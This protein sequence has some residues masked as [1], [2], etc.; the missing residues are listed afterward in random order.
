MLFLSGFI[1]IIVYKLLLNSKNKKHYNNGEGYSGY[2]GMSG[3]SNKD[4]GKIPKSI[5]YVMEGLSIFTL[6]WVKKDAIAK[7]FG[8][9]VFSIPFW[10]LYVHIHNL[11]YSDLKLFY[12]CI[13][14]ISWFFVTGFILMSKENTKGNTI[15]TK[16]ENLLSFYA[17]NAP[18]PPDEFNAKNL[19][20]RPKSQRLM[21]T[22]FGSGSMHPHRD[23]FRKHYDDENCI[24]WTEGVNKIT[25][26]PCQRE[27]SPDE[28]PEGLQ[29]EIDE[30]YRLNSIAY[31]EVPKYE[32]YCK[33]ERMV[34][35][36]FY[37][38]EQ[39][40]N[41]QLGIKNKKAISTEEELIFHAHN[42]TKNY[43]TIK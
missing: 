29:D 31:D 41:H 39:M 40:V 35:W 16:R 33:M 21:S 19:L 2:S 7:Y 36:R 42:L 24:F 8:A 9:I 22:V 10:F 37:Y 32:L 1:S 3:H 43:N 23:F 5:K 25:D 26:E 30:F 14:I 18:E 6:I 38:A 13:L 34:Q 17:C 20:P 4:F 12:Y 11:P 28:I 27:M 15:D